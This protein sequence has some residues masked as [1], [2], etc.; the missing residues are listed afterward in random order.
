MDTKELEQSL[1]MDEILKNIRSVVSEGMEKQEEQEDDVL[2]LTDIV[3]IGN[4]A[5]PLNKEI[6]KSKDVLD[7]INE[8]IGEEIKSKKIQTSTPELAIKEKPEV[9]KN[10][11]LQQ[12][13][14]EE[15]E[16]MV[17]SPKLPDLPLQDN[18]TKST[19]PPTVKEVEE[20][21][22]EEEKDIDPGLKVESSKEESLISE[23]ALEASAKALK[24]LMSEDKT[25][26]KVGDLETKITIEELV[27]RILK[28]ELSRWLDKNLPTIVQKIVEKEIKKI[29]PKAKK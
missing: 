27:I 26:D 16:E 4:L 14:E 10:N 1:S 2:E 28:P 12:A 15:E 20:L 23:Q 19:A 3:E 11:N 9:V 22:I 17:N 13:E 5:N 7:T 24:A 8:V 21:V 18:L 6:Q 29:M 25:F